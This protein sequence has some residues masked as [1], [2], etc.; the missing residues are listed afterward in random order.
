MMTMKL[1]DFNAL[2]ESAWAGA[3]TAYG[4]VTGLRLTPS[5]RVELV[6]DAL[7]QGDAF[8]SGNLSHGAAGFSLSEITNPVTRSVVTIE[9]T[10]GPDEA[11]ISFGT[12]R[13]PLVVIA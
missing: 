7:A 6:Q 4:D 10:D 3:H 5:S 1:S 9:S 11:V 13:S 8:K 2:C 12:H